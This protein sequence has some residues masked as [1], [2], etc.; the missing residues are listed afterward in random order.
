M[1]G[2]EETSAKSRGSSHAEDRDSEMS[3]SDE[4]AEGEE[5][6]KLV[7]PRGDWMSLTNTP[8]RIPVLLCPSNDRVA[9]EYATYTRSAIF[10]SEVAKQTFAY[11]WE[12]GFGGVPHLHHLLATA[13]TAQRQLS[14]SSVSPAES[15]PCGRFS[16]SHGRSVCHQQQVD[17]GARGVLNGKS[18]SM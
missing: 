2:S 1:D 16:C 8:Q 13:S 14:I 18:C 12:G 17:G 6:S 3:D 7:M 5:I 15:T 9:V 10:R 11:V 4:D